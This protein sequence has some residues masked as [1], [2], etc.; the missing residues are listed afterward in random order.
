MIDDFIRFWA[1]QNGDAPAFVTPEATRS[2]A[3][4]EADIRRAVHELRDFRVPPGEAASVAIKSTYIQ[5]VLI[6]AL[7][8]LGI[9]STPSRDARAR[10]RI[11]TQDTD[12]TEH[13]LLLSPGDV[14]RLM[15][16]PDRPYV[17]ARADPEALGRIAL[18]SGTTGTPKRVA[19]SWRAL[20][21]HA[22]QAMMLH[23]DIPGPWMVTMGHQ[24]ISGYRHALAAWAMGKSVATDVGPAA[25]AIAAMKPGLLVLNPVHLNQLLDHIPDNARWPVRVFC[26]GSATPLA[27]LRRL[28][29]DFTTDVILRFASTEA[30]QIASATPRMI[31]E[32]PRAV[33]YPVPGVEV[34]IVDD[35][36][37]ELPP[38]HTGRFCIRNDRLA[39]G[40]LDDPDLTDQ[41]FRDGWFL[42]R[43]LGQK[44]RDGLL[45]VE[46]RIDDVMNLGGHKVSTSKVEDLALQVPGVIDAA[47]FPFQSEKGVDQ[48]GLAVVRGD[49]FDPVELRKHLGGVL[50]RAQNIQLLLCDALPHTP[51]GKVDRR[52]L[53]EIADATFRSPPP[54]TGQATAR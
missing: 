8:R 11:T 45:I 43:D 37:N 27:L 9:A 35:D 52:K 49:G 36:C 41:C 20:Q 30:G 7:A 15:K 38:G 29:P 4:L 33:G 1:A 28:C 26:G 16:G 44:R 10:F 2:F 46:G 47:A 50:M 23:A 39:S 14:E 31:E 34:R 12:D 54:A 6:L 18:T 24:T 19:I 53:R 22:A 40:Y 17:H 21:G 3:Q 25:G 48:C 42:S 32:E 5:W 51:A 13:R